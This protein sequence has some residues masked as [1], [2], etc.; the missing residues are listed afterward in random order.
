MTRATG[1]VSQVRC[2]QEDS[3]AG[4]IISAV[5]LYLEEVLNTSSAESASNKWQL[6]DTR[7]GER[8]ALP[9][10]LLL[11]DLSQSSTYPVKRAIMNLYLT[12]WPREISV[13]LASQ[14]R[15]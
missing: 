3:Y 10:I 8:Q 1:E 12:T 4:M 15:T 5:V 2:A 9:P 11:P 13:N 14:I 7:H 6:F